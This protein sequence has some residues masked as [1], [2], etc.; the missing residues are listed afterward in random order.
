MTEIIRDL[1]VVQ[2]I[3][4]IT[5]EQILWWARRVNAQRAN[6]ALTEATKDIKEF[7]AMKKHKQ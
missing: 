2:E 6:I 4:E 1:T 5:S 3:I 7:D